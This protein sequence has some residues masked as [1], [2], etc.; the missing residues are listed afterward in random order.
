MSCVEKETYRHLVRLAPKA[1]KRQVIHAMDLLPFI[2]KSMGETAIT[3]TTTSISSGCSD[4]NR[5]TKDRLRRRSPPRSRSRSRSRSFSF[6]RR[7]RRR[8]SSRTPDRN[9]LRGSRSFRTTDGYKPSGRNRNTVPEQ[10][11][12]G[13]RWRDLPRKRDQR[14]TADR[15]GRSR[16]WGDGQEEQRS[17]WEFPRSSHRLKTG[18]GTT[19]EIQ[20]ENWKRRERSGVR[21]LRR[22]SGKSTKTS[23]ES[24]CVVGEGKKEDKRLS[25]GPCLQRNDITETEKTAIRH[26]ENM[27][28]SFDLD[29]TSEGSIEMHDGPNSERVSSGTDS[30][31][32]GVRA[33]LLPTPGTT[34]YKAVMERAA[35]TRLGI[36]SLR[37]SVGA[38]SELF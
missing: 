36:L 1:T 37:C 26:S 12:R 15:E 22:R 38:D 6:S 30:P 2:L 18:N 35:T 33:G 23:S 9:R 25:P 4:E 13:R 32:P 29:P 5:S 27:S 21:L 31:R 10:R 28:S 11:L 16:R 34:A 19:A 8:G 17:R 24:G 14:R 7:R 3:T 20:L